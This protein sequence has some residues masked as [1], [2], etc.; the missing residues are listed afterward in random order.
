VTGPADPDPWV[1]RWRRDI[2]AATASAHDQPG[3]QVC[4]DLVKG[5]DRVT[6]DDGLLHQARV[7]EAGVDLLTR[8]RE[9]H[10]RYHDLNHL[11]AV[12]TALDL[13][14]GG[15]TTDEN[16]PGE[17]VTGENVTSP[18]V[19]ARLSAWFHDAVYAG[20]P[21]Q[22]EAA[23]ADLAVAVLT[24]LGMPRAVVTEVDRLVRMTA[25]H[26]D[27]PAGATEDRAGALLSDADLAIL[28]APE[29]DYRRYTQAVRAEYAHVS[30]ADFRRGRAAV[31]Q[32]LLAAE[33]LYRTETGRRLWQDAARAN[34][35]AE[36]GL[37]T[38]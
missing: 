3:P 35:R 10:R 11:D 27:R 20:R 30:D 22:D 17:N 34:L 23:S 25:D 26:A 29:A 6:G 9:P 32:R 19:V 15:P 4:G 31:L 13:L 36:L 21:G 18:V 7:E 24:R 28:A 33:P 14:T 38:S 1:E 5:D 2:A 16:P 37:L 12:L 8:W